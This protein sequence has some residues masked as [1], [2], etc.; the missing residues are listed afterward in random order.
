MPTTRWP[1]ASAT[2]AS[3]AAGSTRSASCSSGRPSSVARSALSSRPGPSPSRPSTTRSRSAATAPGPSVELDRAHDVGAGGD[4]QRR[5]VEHEPPARLDGHVELQ[6][7]ARRAGQRDR[8][9]DRHEDERRARPDV[10][11]HAVVVAGERPGLGRHE[12]GAH[13]GAAAQDPRREP[14]AAHAV[15]APAPCVDREDGLVSAGERGGGRE[16]PPRSS[17][18][19]RARGR[20]RAARA[21]S[22]RRARRRRRSRSDERVHRQ[23]VAAA[24]RLGEHPLDVGADVRREVG[25]VDDE[26]VGAGDAGAALA[27]D[28]VAGRDVDH[29]RLHVGERGA[30]DRRQVVAAALDE[31]EVERAGGG[32]ELARRPR[33]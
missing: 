22:R 20:R 32:L 29:E 5:L 10:Q 16:R 7:R 21:P 25:L 23:R 2:W 14:R 17:A 33:G 28:V 1:G 9:G 11:P 18:G 31:H 12:R 8:R 6:T 19:G 4:D 24:A 15:R 13:H 3:C 30:E 27:R 26:Q